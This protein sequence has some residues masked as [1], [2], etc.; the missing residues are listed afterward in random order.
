MN[1]P[2]KPF[3]T[4]EQQLYNLQNE[5]MLIISNPSF[6]DIVALY[7]FDES[8][9]E[10]VFKYICRIEQKLRTEISYYFCNKYSSNQMDYLNSDNYNN[11]GKML[12]ESAVL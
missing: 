10:L 6:E 5:K 4:Y 12:T 8:L 1:K 7:Y 9:R 3:L 2:I 11:R